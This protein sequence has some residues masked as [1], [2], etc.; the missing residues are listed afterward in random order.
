VQDAARLRPHLLEDRHHLARGK[1][2]PA[3][4]PE[5]AAWLID[6]IDPI[7]NREGAPGMFIDAQFGAHIDNLRV[8][9]ND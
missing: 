6:R 4:E 2:W 7:G 3:G 9:R 1:A 5:P 8:T